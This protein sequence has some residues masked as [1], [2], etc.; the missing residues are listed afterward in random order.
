MRLGVWPRKE[1]ETPAVFCPEKWEHRCQVEQP[2][3]APR[4]EKE[5]RSV[6]SA[7]T[8][9]V[10]DSTDTNMSKTQVFK[11]CFPQESTFICFK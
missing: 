10:Q 1:A 7:L 2:L 5:N 3:Q 11:R 6:V 9:H 8:T 4:E